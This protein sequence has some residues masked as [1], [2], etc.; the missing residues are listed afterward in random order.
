MLCVVIFFKQFNQA[1]PIH[2]RHLT[3]RN[4]AS[5]PLLQIACGHS[6]HYVVISLLTIGRVGDIGISCLIKAVHDQLIKQ[7]GVL[8]NQDGDTA[9]LPGTQL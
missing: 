4:Q 8:R 3:I 6:C 9:S 1:V 7:L 2:L 5:Y